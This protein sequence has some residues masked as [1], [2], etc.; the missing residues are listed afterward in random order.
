MREHLLTF[1]RSFG[2][3][4]MQQQAH[5]PNTRRV[6]ALAEYARDQGRLDEARAIGMDAYWRH[7]KNLED[8]AVLREIA[9][10]AGLDGDAALAA[11]KDPAYLDRIDA[12]REEAESIGVTGIPTF[13]IGSQRRRMPALRSARGVRHGRGRRRAPVDR[14]LT[15]ARRGSSGSGRDRG[16]AR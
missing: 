4:D 16:G 10:A 2:I 1:A 5:V 15:A 14:R 9:V 3:D 12:R 6:I 11:T 7:G 13:V 8:D